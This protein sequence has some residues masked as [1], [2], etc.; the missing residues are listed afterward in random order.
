MAD[1]LVEAALGAYR[2]AGRVLSPGLGLLLRARTLAG[3]EMLA[4]RSERFGRPDLARPDG[5]LV[6]FHAASVG[7]TVSVLPLIEAI[8]ARGPR[9]L[10]TTGTVTSAA[11]AA[12]RLPARSLHQFAPLDVTTFAG[13]FLDHWKPDLAIFVESEIWPATV[14]EIARRS[15]PQVIVNARM[16]DRSA[17][18]WQGI[19][20]VARALFGRLSLVLA[21]S[22]RDGDRLR[23]L[24]AAPVIVSGNLKFDGSMLEVEP[25]DLAKLRASVGNRPVWLAASTHPGEEDIA[26]EVHKQ[27]VERHPDLLT[28]IVPRHPERGTAIRAALLEAGITAVA[29]RSLGE[30]PTAETTVF[31]GDTIGEMGLYYRAAPIA[32]LGGSLVDRGG[33]N[34]IEAAA[35]GTGVVHGPRVGNFVD[36]YRTFDRAGGAVEIDDADGLLTAMRRHLADPAATEI[37]A[38]TALAI[39]EANRGALARTLMAIEPYLAALEPPEAASASSLAGAE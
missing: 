38:R 34:P 23:E 22:P 19:A 14:H 9:V 2:I 5:P 29:Q 4:R 21:Q 27:L 25:D 6:W 16:S 32:F 3:K 7:E 35:L 39:V 18:R 1:P 37:R 15:I 28:L 26:A 31:L 20:G 36:V 30:W 8:C 11:V 17:S 24:G 33:Q 13:R 12:R 10:L